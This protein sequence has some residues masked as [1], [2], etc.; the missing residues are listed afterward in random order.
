[1]SMSMIED[2]T[3]TAERLEAT[4]RGFY[5]AATEIH[6]AVAEIKRLAGERAGERAGGTA[7]E[8]VAL[9]RVLLIAHV[10]AGNA[11]PLRWQQVGADWHLL[12][13]E[14]EIY[15]G[16]GPLPALTS[17]ARDLIVRTMDYIA[18]EEGAQP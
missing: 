1:M 2:W 13:T 9:Q 6:G 17:E 10:F 16:N 5:S 14:A 3:K 18:R 8:V 12:G 7:E 15:C 4:S 11:D